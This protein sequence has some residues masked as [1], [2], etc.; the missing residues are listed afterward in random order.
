MNNLLR[1]LKSYISVYLN[2]PI[3]YSTGTFSQDGEDIILQDIFKNIE[4]GFY[5]DVGAHHPFRFSNTQSFYLNGWHGINIEP[6]P[7]AKKLFD[8][9]RKR[10][11]NFQKAIGKTKGNI[12]LYCFNDP[13]LNTTSYKRAKKTIESKQSRL[14][15]KVSVDVDTLENIFINNIKD[16]KIDFLNIDV[17][18]KELEVLQ[19]NN[20]KRYSPDVVVV[21]NLKHTNTIPNYLKEKGY[22]LTGKTKMSEVYKLKK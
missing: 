6:T 18:G 7:D 22:T 19:S 12:I 16:I 3:L 9:A 17:E 14:I 1:K 21:E 5:V 13:A 8:I 11:T 2:L 10:D 15:E 20:W 4:K